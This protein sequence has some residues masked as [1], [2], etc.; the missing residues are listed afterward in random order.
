MDSSS[1]TTNSSQFAPEVYGTVLTVP[2]D[3]VG[4]PLYT[5]LLR[6]GPN[7]T[8]AGSIQVSV[9]DSLVVVPTALFTSAVRPEYAVISVS[10]A[11]PGD[12]ISEVLSASTRASGNVLATQPISI[13][14]SIWERSI[15]GT[16]NASIN[17]TI[18]ITQ[19]NATGDVT[20]VYWDEQQD[21]WSSQGVATLSV[22]DGFVQ[23]STTHLSLF[24]AVVAA[25]V[26]TLV[27]SNAA[28]IFSV[29][30]LQSLLEWHWAVRAP[31]LVQWVT[32]LVG[33]V[34]LLAAKHMDLRHMERVDALEGF[35]H[36]KVL[37]P[38]GPSRKDFVAD[39]KEYFLGA[40]H[41]TR[42]VASQLLKRSIGLGTGELN[43][44][45][46]VSGVTG[47]HQQA[48][49][50]LSHFSEQKLLFK[51]T[52]LYQVNCRWFSFATPSLKATCTQRCSV[53]LAK[54][55][56]GWAIMALFYDSTA[57]A[58]GQP[59][60]APPE[61][62][63]DKLVRSAV[64]AWISA[65]F[66]S[67]PFVM[68][69]AVVHLGGN[70][71]RSLRTNIFWSY[72]TL[73]TTLCALVVSIFLASVSPAD[74]EKFLISSLTNLFTSVLVTPLL[75]TVLFGICLLSRQ[76]DLGQMLQWRQDDQFGISIESVEIPLEQLH[77]ALKL[78]SR[79]AVTVV[80]EVFGDHSSSVNLK[81]VSD[82]GNTFSSTAAILVTK[83]Q[84]LFFTIVLVELQRRSTRTL[85]AVVLGGDV[86]T[87]YSGSLPLFLA[88]KSSP[89]AEAMVQVGL[90]T[91]NEEKLDTNG[92]HTSKDKD[93]E[94]GKEVVTIDVV[95]LEKPLKAD[96]DQRPDH[97]EPRHDVPLRAAAAA[98]RPQEGTMTREMPPP[99]P[100]PKAHLAE[101]EPAPEPLLPAGS[102]LLELPASAPPKSMPRMGP[103]LRPQA[104]TVGAPRPDP[105]GRSNDSS[106]AQHTQSDAGISQL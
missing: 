15:N 70:R 24:A 7:E 42:R 72:M 36:I 100:T 14:L 4:T 13:K 30:G 12:E 74:E 60:C 94:A 82:S 1:N 41:P 63:L 26:N 85:H 81:M 99:D 78:D 62:L 29:Q 104:R 79:L 105:R 55:Y 5:S 98:P 64:V 43:R 86:I 21:R 102:R 18:P 77:A 32:L 34:L 9:G 96:A 87:G 83:N 61:A 48:R 49:S 23:C 69:L 93:A 56:S 20:C 80:V 2:H 45:R 31:A 33:L 53:L 67:L 22:A 8:G 97:L 47:W 66:G 35:Q 71:A 57:L 25:V 50:V 76:G 46:Q 90:S 39:L 16:L 19:A 68:L 40:L 59:E 89:C 38:V 51:L 101:P 73:H 65:A 44:L 54:L 52:M 27:C 10:D 106:E 75:L 58:P 3:H 103:C 84:V 6:A 95:S 88:G 92:K 17:F 91:R 28:G 11:Q 37:R